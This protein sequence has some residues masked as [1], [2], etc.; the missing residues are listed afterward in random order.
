MGADLRSSRAWNQPSQL[1]VPQ[2]EKYQWFA[3]QR[4]KRSLDD[5]N[6]RGYPFDN[7]GVT[8]SCWR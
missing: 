1:I 3:R 8:E 5:E 7:A 2:F 6:C 4:S